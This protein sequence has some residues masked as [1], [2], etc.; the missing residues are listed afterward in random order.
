[1]LF[2]TIREPINQKNKLRLKILEIRNLKTWRYTNTDLKICQY[3]CLQM[4]RK[5]VEDFTLKHFLL[6][7]IRAREVCEKFVYKHWE[8]IECAKN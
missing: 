6:F 4:K 2:Y 8:T 3:L 7:E 1:M 5:Y